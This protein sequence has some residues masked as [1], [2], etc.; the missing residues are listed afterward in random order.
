MR[1]GF[2]R[3]EFTA[4]LKPLYAE[5]Y[6]NNIIHHYLSFLTNKLRKIK[7]VKYF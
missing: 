5:N 2:L 4:L 7:M 1:I 3:C 6:Q